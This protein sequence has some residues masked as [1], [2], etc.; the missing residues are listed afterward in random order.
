MKELDMEG[1]E[2]TYLQGLDGPIR[3]YVVASIQNV[4]KD[5]D[6][7]TEWRSVVEPILKSCGWKEDRV[8]AFLEHLDSHYFAALYTR[9]VGETEVV[10]FESPVQMSASKLVLDGANRKNKPKTALD[11]LAGRRTGPTHVDRA[12]LERV[13][14]RH[15]QR[16][17]KRQGITADAETSTAQ[18]SAIASED[19]QASLDA[20]QLEELLAHGLQGAPRQDLRIDDFDIALGGKRILTNA[21]LTLSYGRI[22]GLVG[23]NGIGKSTLLRAISRRDLPRLPPNLS[24]LHVEQEAIG[25]D[26]PV[27]DAVLQ[28]DRRRHLLKLEE[29]RLQHNLFDEG[30]LHR[31]QTLLQEMEA[32]AAVAQAATILTGLGFQSEEQRR[33]TRQF[34]G[35]WRMRIA[36]A[37]A[38]FCQPDL[39]LLDEPTNMLD[40]EAVAWLENHL[41]DRWRGTVV[42]V[43]HDRAFLNA[44]AT[45][46]LHLHHEQLDSYRGNYEQFVQTKEERLKN[47][48]REYDNQLAYRQQLQSF[49]D[50]WRCNANRASQAQSRLKVLEKLPDL[51]PPVVIEPTV[52]FRFPALGET[53][54]SPVLSLED[55]SFGYANSNSNDAAANKNSSIVPLILKHVDLA[56]ESRGRMAI[57]GPN[58]AGKTTLLKLLTGQLDP[59]GGVARQNARVR[60]GYFSQHYVD[61]LDLTATPLEMMTRQNAGA[62]DEELRRFLGAFGLTGPLALQRIATL[63]GGQKSRVVLAGLAAQRPHVLLMDEPTN[64][65]DMDSIDALTQACRDFEG[66]V[67]AVSHDQ[68]FVSVLCGDDNA[69]AEERGGGGLWVCAHGTVSR[70]RGP[71][72]IRGYVHSLRGQQ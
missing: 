33:P 63:S 31:V 41:I 6:D 59:T 12:K 14:A 51:P 35:G 68:R 50:R 49:I 58:G 23:R 11:W 26:T 25:D 37:S 34:S 30:R 46:I 10:P 44:V 62:T 24:I 5:Q 39:L 65:L 38:L 56:V 54:P 69:E 47:A 57:V 45:D 28:A 9:V 42:V 53:L 1:L 22:Y 18:K 27:L 48:Q 17:E 16:K 4:L 20:A 19:T 72:G 70:Y 66:A 32:D 8:A 13:E 15:R 36:L 60:I 67:I 29:A 7:P 52:V 40:I 43:S 71:D 61:Q 55:V 3:T 21:S 64:H 2:T